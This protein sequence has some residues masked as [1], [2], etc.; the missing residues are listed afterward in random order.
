M[1]NLFLPALAAI[2][3]V[4]PAAMAR[5]V[6]AQAAPSAPPWRPIPTTRRRGG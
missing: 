6:H 1:R 3:L 5:P 2:L 4:T